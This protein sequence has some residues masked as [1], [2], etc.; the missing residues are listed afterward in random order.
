V[1]IAQ[2]GPMPLRA[3]GVSGARLLATDLRVAT[4]LLNDA[5]YRMFQRV[6]AIERRDVNMVTVVALLLMAERAQ[7]TTRRVRSGR[8]PNM[9]ENFMGFGT[10]REA[11]A[12]VA[13]PDSRDTPLLS[14]LLAIAVIGSAARSGLH[15]IRGSGHTADVA[16]HRRYGYLIDPGHWRQRR[17]QRRN[18]RPVSPPV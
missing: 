12:R 11:L 9:A 17:A 6:F 13:G 10:V 8:G 2:D 15:G 1:S 5:R 4:L 3:T 14:T 18:G 16:F 7:T